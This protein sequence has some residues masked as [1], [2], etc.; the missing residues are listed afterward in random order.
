MAGLGSQPILSIL[1]HVP[2]GL[3]ETPANRIHRVLSGPTLIHLPGRRADPLFVSVL[4]HGNED[5]GLKALQTVL[6]KH[7]SQPLPR[8][9]SVYI[10]NIEAAAHDRRRLD[11]QPDYNRVWPGAD[12]FGLPEHRMMERIVDEMRRRNVFA[13]I[14]IHNN[15]GTNPNYACVN[16]LDERF[17]Y[18]A[19][20]F[21]RVIVH[22]QRPLGVQSA[23]FSEL[24]PAITVECGKPGNAANDRRAV[25]LIEA[26]LKLDHFP[27]HPVP[28]QDLD[29]YHTVG[30]V[31]V[32][33]E[34]TF[35]FGPGTADIRFE[36]AIDHMNFRDLPVGTPLAEL[37]TS[38]GIPL[39]VWAEDGSRVTDDYFERTATQLRLKLPATPSML[40]L[41]ERAIR[42]DCLCY[43]M[44]RISLLD[45]RRS[46]QG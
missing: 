19:T 32:P 46:D 15:T 38:D 9:L 24:C 6:A 33:Q 29:L 16:Q 40:T 20:L 5:T 35:T 34:V 27:A 41:D 36:P 8:A 11:G 4:L 18:L 39:D 21:A 7:E 14:D 2:R 28:R 43:L 25:E 22:F 23:A 1:D 44:Q 37:S 17:L 31:K 26:A 45:E 13:S 30:T 42:Q 12:T 3:V 10:G